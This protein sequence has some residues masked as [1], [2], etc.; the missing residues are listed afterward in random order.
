MR[1]KL[2]TITVLLLSAV[3]CANDEPKN[4]FITL[5]HD[6]RAPYRKLTGRSPP[7]LW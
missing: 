4:A 5:G 7:T 3:A 1:N 2:A 6:G